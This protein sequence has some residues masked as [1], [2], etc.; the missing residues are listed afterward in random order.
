[1][2]ISSVLLAVI[3]VMCGDDGHNEG[4]YDN[5]ALVINIIIAIC[6]LANNSRVAKHN[7]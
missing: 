7:I 3:L 4:R 5:L 1:M 6:N 2:V